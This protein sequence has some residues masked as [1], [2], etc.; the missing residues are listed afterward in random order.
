[1]KQNQEMTREF[2]VYRYPMLE[3]DHQH[4]TMR[5]SRLSDQQISCAKDASES[6]TID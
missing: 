6:Y 1:M 4:N 5:L 2:G 3:E